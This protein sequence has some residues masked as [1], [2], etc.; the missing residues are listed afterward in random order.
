MSTRKEMTHDPRKLKLAEGL[1]L[2]VLILGVT[3]AV[4]V[5]VASR[6]GDA[7]PVEVAEVVET[8]PVVEESVV[9]PEVIGAEV[10][11]AE[12]VAEPVEPAPLFTA[13][14][15]AGDIYREGEAAYHARDYDLAADAFAVYVERKPQNAWGHYMRGLSL[16]KAGALED[17]E[18][19]LREALALSPEHVKSQVNLARVL[20]AQDRPA[21]ALPVIEA[22]AALLPDDAGIKRMTGRVLHNLDRRD[23]AVVAYR[24]ALAIDPDDTWALNNLGLLLIETDRCDDAVAPLARAVGLADDVAVFR[25]NLGM[26]L[27]R[28]G[29]PGQAAEAYAAALEI[30]A[31]YEKAD[32]SLARIEPVAAAQTDAAPLDLV[33][34]AAAFTTAP[35]PEALAVAEIDAAPDELAAAEIEQ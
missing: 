25:N 27:E 3:I 7:S 35:E 6:D 31:T 34:L 8:A 20:L 24:E 33:A 11:G 18:L 28:S 5:N 14:M 30:D 4:G 16:M 19:A 2:F 21:A 15:P 23:E 9:G 1:V 29:H 13:D 17:S 10:I 22:A 12:P 32:V 26:A